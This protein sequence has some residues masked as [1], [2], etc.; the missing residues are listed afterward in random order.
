MYAVTLADVRGA[1]IP[2]S[3]LRGAPGM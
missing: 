1:V 2:G 3:L